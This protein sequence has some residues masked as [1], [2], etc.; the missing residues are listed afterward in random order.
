VPYLTPDTE[1]RVITRPLYIPSEF[2]PIITGQLSEL[3]N[4]W[5]WE[6]FGTLTVAECQEVIDNILDGYFGGNPL[7]GTIQAYVLDTLP[8][9]ALICDGSSYSFD[10]Y[11]NLL[12]RLPTS[13]DNGD[14]TFTV[15]DLTEL[16][17][18]G[19]ATS[20]IGE[21]GGENS[22]ALSAE[23]NAS[24]TH[25]IQQGYGPDVAASVVLGALSGFQAIPTEETTS[26]QG[27]GQAHENRPPFWSVVYALIAE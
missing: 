10:D 25:T 12:G 17:L 13:I 19:G 22:V 18:R 6:P 26:S 1:G 24:H 8:Q 20:D 27:S 16:F 23:Q 15:P 4:E 11:P 5:N 14:G 21:T 7:I 9:G 2:L 3:R